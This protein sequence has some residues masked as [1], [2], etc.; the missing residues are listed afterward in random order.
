[1]VGNFFSTFGQT[2][3]FSMMT[4]LNDLLTN[5]ANGYGIP[6]LIFFI[7]GLVLAVGIGIFGYKLIKLLNAAILAVA[8]YYL[9]GAE[10]YFF[11]VNT[12]GL[13]T[14]PVWAPYIPA[15][16]FGVLFFLFAFFKPTYAYYTIMAALGYIMAYFYTQ[17]IF[18]AL[19]GAVLLALLCMFFV[20]VS[21]IILTSVAGGFLA[22]AMLGG[23]LPGVAV[24]QFTANNWLALGIAGGIALIFAIIQLIITRKDKPIVASPVKGKKAKKK[25][26]DE[27]EIEAEEDAP[28]AKKIRRPKEYTA[29]S[30]WVALVLCIL[31]GSFGVHKFYEGRVG[32]GILYLLTGGL[33][34]IGVLVDFILILCKPGDTYYV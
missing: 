14:L 7:V 12:F 1:M 31:T 24:L 28:K 16:I 34:G 11:V 13:T 32:L 22:T 29:K 25:A 21:F 30:K 20:R 4:Q 2:D 27:D 10:L 8:G 17:N 26:D 19:G 5:T 9:V 6:T 18:L 3:L 23:I 33:F 15:I